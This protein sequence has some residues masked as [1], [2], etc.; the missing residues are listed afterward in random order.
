M[1][2]V[3]LLSWHSGSTCLFKVSCVS[4]ST[5][6]S[7]LLPAPSPTNT[8]QSTSAF[9]E[10]AH[11][12]GGGSSGGALGGV[13][14]HQCHILSV[15][16]P[17]IWFQSHPLLPFSAGLLFRSWEA[18]GLFCFG[19]SLWK[20]PGNCHWAIFMFATSFRSS[21]PNCLESREWVRI[22]EGRHFFPVTNLGVA[23]P[24]WGSA[25]IQT[26]GSKPP[27]TC[28]FPMSS[29]NELNW[30]GLEPLI[31][32]LLG[33]SMC[34]CHNHRKDIN[35]LRYWNFLLLPSRALGLLIEIDKRPGKK[36]SI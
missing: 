15:F 31:Q 9:L 30:E 10:A 1:S 20:Q 8:W 26:F 3:F 35:R 33:L 14:H 25:V 16:L 36:F 21:V 13:Y 32:A 17:G 4:S 19:Y 12:Q 29:L 2:S 24:R 18:F 28:N 27:F 6:C 7:T 23:L 5:C 34:G 11:S 22:L